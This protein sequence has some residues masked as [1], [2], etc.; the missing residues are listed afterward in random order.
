[1]F[2]SLAGVLASNSPYVLSV[3]SQFT[4]SDCTITHAYIVHSCT[5]SSDFSRPPLTHAPRHETIRCNCSRGAGVRVRL[6]II[7]LRSLSP[8][9]TTT[10]L[11]RKQKGR[12]GK[13][14]RVFPCPFFFSPSLC[15]FTL[16]LS[17]VRSALLFSF[18]FFLS[19]YPLERC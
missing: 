1:M 3:S 6:G 5:H 11:Q 8:L 7:G 16:S 12:R 4:T 15:P 13:V 2:A 18:C 10:P 9:L 17:H 14:T 19:L